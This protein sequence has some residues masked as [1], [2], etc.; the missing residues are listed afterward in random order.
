MGA[1]GGDSLVTTRRR[2]RPMTADTPLAR[3]M[4]DR[5]MPRAELAKRSGV[6]V[7]TIRDL[8]AGRRPMLTTA[9]AVAKALGVRVETL[10]P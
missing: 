4:I 7:S 8:L 1:A 10:W 5:D 6:P 9:Q 2:G 3:A